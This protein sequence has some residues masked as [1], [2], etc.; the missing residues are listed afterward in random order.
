M[1]YYETTGWRGVMET[2]T[3]PGLPERFHTRPGMLYP[4]YHV[5]ADVGEFADGEA[6]EAISSDPRR[7]DALALRDG[8]R[9]RVLLANMADAP[10]RVRVEGVG[11]RGTRALPGRRELRAGDR[12]RRRIPPRTG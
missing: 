5:L 7:T 3:G 6:L 4:L 8:P 11:A 9:T 12:R 2:P 1:T 10:C